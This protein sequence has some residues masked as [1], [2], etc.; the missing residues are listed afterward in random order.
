MCFLCF[1]IC[2]RF[3]PIY[4]PYRSPKYVHTCLS[5]CV[6]ALCVA[7]VTIEVMSVQSYQCRTLLHNSVPNTLRCWNT[8]VWPRSNEHRKLIGTFRKTHGR[9]ME[10]RTNNRAAYRAA[11]RWRDQRPPRPNDAATYLERKGPK[12]SA[13]ATFQTNEHQQNILGTLKNDD[14]GSQTSAFALLGQGYR[15]KTFVQQKNLRPRHMPWPWLKRLD[16][17]TSNRGRGGVI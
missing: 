17:F 12:L 4:Y 15:L 14:T 2:K 11:P 9:N 6:H 3:S 7:K 8:G 5:Q 1:C 13:R 10:R 16:G